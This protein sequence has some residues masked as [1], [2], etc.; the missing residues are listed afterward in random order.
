MKTMGCGEKDLGG[1]ETEGFAR[2]SAE[3]LNAMASIGAEYISA[4]LGPSGQ[5]RQIL[6]PH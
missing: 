2:S 6:T 1:G 3:S 4:L 5:P